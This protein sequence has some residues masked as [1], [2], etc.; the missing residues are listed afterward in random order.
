MDDLAEISPCYTIT[1][2]RRSKHPVERLWRAITDADEVS[3]WMS[4]RARIDLRVGGDY[5][6]DFGAPEGAP[7]GSNLDGII[8]RLETQ[9][10]LAFV[11]WM[12]V[13]EWRLEP[14]EDGSRYTF[15][16]HGQ[17]PPVSDETDDI[18]AGWHLMLDEFDA[19]LEGISIDPAEVRAKHKRINPAYLEL[20]NAALGR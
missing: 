3:R 8:V 15:S 7:D 17:W 6:V 12:S 14:T 10:R 19:Q 16:H 13:L 11:W 1:F 2:K 4:H 18:P 5:F 20:R 9:R